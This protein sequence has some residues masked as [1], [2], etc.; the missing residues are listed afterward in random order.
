MLTNAQRYTLMGLIGDYVDDPGVYPMLADFADDCGLAYVG[1]QEGRYTLLQLAHL[2]QYGTMQARG[3]RADI[4]RT[5][6]GFVTLVW[7]GRAR[8]DDRP[9]FLPLPTQF[10]CTPTAREAEG[11]W[12]YY[13]QLMSYTSTRRYYLLISRAHCRRLVLRGLDGE[14]VPRD[15]QR[16]LS[17]LV[18]LI[19]CLLR[20][21][22][23][24]VSSRRE[25][26]RE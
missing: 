5:I 2:C 13:H 8:G 10:P 23:S 26:V 1:P 4:A 16:G 9:E 3:R 22:K 11:S 17:F 15:V 24:P 12:R 18:N 7:S 25:A 20:S 21:L 19:R 6:E 14:D